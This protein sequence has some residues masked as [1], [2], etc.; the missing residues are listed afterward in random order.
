MIA[1]LQRY[2]NIITI[3][4]VV[5]AAFVAYIIFFTPERSAPLSVTAVSGAESAVEQELL[6]LLLELRSITL[7]ESIFSD[8]RFRALKDLSQDIVTEPI[9][10]PNP[11]APLGQ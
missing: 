7:D 5:I 2:K 3:A 1:L 10:R 9:G 6:T 8:D 11:F 4:L